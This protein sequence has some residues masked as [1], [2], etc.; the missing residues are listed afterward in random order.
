M[1]ADASAETASTKAGSTQNQAPLEVLDRMNSSASDPI[2]RT[3]RFGMDRKHVRHQL[4]WVFLTVVVIVGVVVIAAPGIFTHLDPITPGEQIL[5]GP[6][7]AHWFGTDQLGRDVFTRVVYGSRPVLVA[8][9]LG[10]GLATLGGVTLGVVGGAAPRLLGGVVMRVVDVLLALPVLLIALLVMAT[11][12]TGLTSIMI[13]VG[14]AYT[15]GFARVI[16][17]SVRKLRS[18]EYVQA[19]KVFGSTGL[20][21]AL[22]HLLPNLA[23]EIVVLI[24]SAIGWA[25][26]TATTLSFLGLGV[27]LPAPDWGSDLAAGATYLS[28]AWWLSTFPGAAIAVTILLANFLGDH[29]VTALDPRSG[30]RP[31]QTLRRVFLGDKALVHG[32]RAVTASR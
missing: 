23:T 9:V 10:V 13:A 4:G 27:R 21:T 12:G 2:V 3:P 30:M 26:L 22:R 18:A 6:S 5:Q 7:G 25:V 15:P 20:R 17:S 14:I 29:V 16:S 31:K 8:G 24:S 28:T 1:S 32:R 11:V 19:A